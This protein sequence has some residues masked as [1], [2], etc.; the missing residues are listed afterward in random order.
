MVNRICQEFPLCGLPLVHGPAV[1]W[2][3]P[4]LT[5]YRVFDTPAQGF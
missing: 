2:L 4:A 1:F 3:Q 5:N